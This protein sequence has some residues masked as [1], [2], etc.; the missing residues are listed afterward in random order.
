MSAIGSVSGM[1]GVALPQVVSGASMRMPPSQKMSNLF[2]QIDVGNSGSIAKSQFDQA[3]Q[4]MN[5]PKGFQQ[6]GSGPVWLALDPGG[7]GSVSK[8]DFVK[9]MTALMSQIRNPHSND[10]QEN[11]A[12]QALSASANALNN[13]GGQP[14]G[15]L[16]NNVN[17]SA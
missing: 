8:Q 11:S 16:G 3:F 9:T 10:T 4:G 6:M 1:G 7:T 2:Q 17:T 5:P 13:L 14:S 12:A 15:P